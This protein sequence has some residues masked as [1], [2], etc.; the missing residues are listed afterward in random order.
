M[1]FRRAYVLSCLTF[2]LIFAA[3]VPMFAQSAQPEQR[4]GE[5]NLVVPELGQAT[6]LNGIS[7]RALLTGGLLIPPL[8][9]VFGLIIYQ[10][11]K[12]LPVHSAMREI[13]ELI[14]ETC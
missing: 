8:G 1:P 10:R 14:S 5:V 13:S 6:F 7:G 9:L 4:G 3:S 2:V 11:L 12:N